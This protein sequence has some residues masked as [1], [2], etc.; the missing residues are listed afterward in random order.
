MVGSDALLRVTEIAT[1]TVDDVLG[2]SDGSRTVTIRTSKTDQDGRGHTRYLG[3]RPR[4]AVQ[5]WIEASA[6]VPSPVRAGPPR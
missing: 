2:Q 4:A 6:S 3:D 1:L 5:R